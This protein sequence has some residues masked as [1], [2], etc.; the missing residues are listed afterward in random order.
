MVASKAAEAAAIPAV[1]WWLRWMGLGTATG[2][3]QLPAGSVAPSLPGTEAGQ[4]HAP[5]L[6][7]TGQ[8]W[9]AWGRALHIP[10][11]A[12]RHLLQCLE[13]HSSG[14]QMGLGLWHWAGD[15]SHFSLE[16]C[17]VCPSKAPV[18][19]HGCKQPVSPGAP[20]QPAL[21]LPLLILTLHRGL[22]ASSPSRRR[23]SWRPTPFTISAPKGRQERKEKPGTA[24]LW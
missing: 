16:H 19:S 9:V 10:G 18:L 12:L 4:L 2:R 5:G 13:V 20:G 1:T 3:Q 7:A 15:R 17:S 24:A 22:T 6:V 23:K 11:A 8:P 14:G 21:P